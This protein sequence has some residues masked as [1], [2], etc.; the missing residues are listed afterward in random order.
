M[1]LWRYALAMS[2]LAAP[3]SF[4]LLYLAV[5]CCE[6]FGVDVDRLLPRFP[7]SKSY[8]LVTACI[9]GPIIETLLLALVVFILSNVFERRM[10]AAACSAL[11]WGALHGFR[12]PLWF[13]GTA[14]SFYVFSAAFLARRHES[15][16]AAFAAAAVPHMIQNLSVVALM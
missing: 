8:M 16:R 12:A 3:L 10:V 5:K 7:E 9:I 15:F 4:L 1:P 14:W 2:L 13:F 6:L 11:L